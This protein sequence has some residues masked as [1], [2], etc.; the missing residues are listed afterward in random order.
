M[1]G[2]KG[3]EVNQGAILRAF[4]LGDFLF[5]EQEKMKQLHLVA[6][7][8]IIAIG[9]LGRNTKNYK[10]F[11]CIL[12]QLA[13]LAASLILVMTVAC[14]SHADTDRCQY[15]I[16][17]KRLEQDYLADEG[18]GMLLGYGK[19]SY[20]LEQISKTYYHV[21]IGKYV[22]RSPDLRHIIN[23]GYNRDRGPVTVY[24]M[25]VRMSY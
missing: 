4:C 21:Q 6:K 5:S 11:S 17:E 12:N 9:A 10:A 20:G 14:H 3:D 15:P 8:M 24:S 16:A 25:R 19:L 7:W 13:I 23:P 1:A 22:Q 2:R 18:L